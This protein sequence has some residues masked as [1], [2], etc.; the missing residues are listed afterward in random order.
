LGFDIDS[1]PN[2]ELMLAKIVELKITA[3]RYK[4]RRITESRGISVLFNNYDK[5]SDLM[6]NNP[7]NKRPD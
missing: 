4:A 6:L 5:A 1:I 3:N 7:F 2:D